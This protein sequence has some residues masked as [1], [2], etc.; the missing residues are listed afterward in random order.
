MAIKTWNATALTGGATRALDAIAISSLTDGDRAFVVASGKLYVYEF[1]SS[2][3]DAETMPTTTQ[4]IRPDDYATAGVWVNIVSPIDPEMPVG[5]IIAWPTSTAPS[6]YRECNGDPVS[7]TETYDSLFA[8]IGITYGS[9]D[10]STTFN[11]PDYRGYFLRGW[12]HGAGIDDDAATRTTRGDVAATTGDNVGTRQDHAMQTHTH[13]VGTYPS[14]EGD[15]DN[16]TISSTSTGAAYNIA[17][18]APTGV[19]SATETRPINVNV[20]WIIKY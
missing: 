7:R 15:G 11:L 2:A 3:T 10:A 13:T 9:G 8:V 14:W 18:A 6:G 1:D 12:D 17:S 5:T 16:T 4:Y 19:I 20:M